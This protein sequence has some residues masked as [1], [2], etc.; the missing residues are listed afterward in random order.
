MRSLKLITLF[1]WEFMADAACGLL[2]ALMGGKSTKRGV[3]ITD[4]TSLG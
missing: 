1:T 2:L 4:Q 3:V